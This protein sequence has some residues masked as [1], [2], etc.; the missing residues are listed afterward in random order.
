MQ[1]ESK[2]RRKKFSLQQCLGALE[3]SILKKSNVGLYNGLGRTDEQFKNLTF[4]L[5]LKKFSF[6]RIWRISITAKN[7][8]KLSTSHLI[9]V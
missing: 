1:K 9:M 4:L 6:L 5:S 2:I 3:N 8:G 7:Q